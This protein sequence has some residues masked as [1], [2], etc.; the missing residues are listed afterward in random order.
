METINDD[1]KQFEQRSESEHENE[2]EIVLELE[3]QFR[4]VRLP[5]EIAQMIFQKVPESEVFN[6]RVFYHLTFSTNIDDQTMLE[7]LRKCML[8]IRI[9]AVEINQGSFD[10]A[11]KLLSGMSIV[12]LHITLGMTSKSDMNSLTAITNKNTIEHL[13]VILRDV[14][15]HNPGLTVLT[16]LQLLST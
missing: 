7:F 16:G 1:H 9:R 6:L 10:V 8:G 12:Q 3:S 5:L 2:N 13:S 4:L 15:I 11:S 14:A